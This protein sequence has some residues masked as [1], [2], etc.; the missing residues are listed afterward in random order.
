MQIYQTLQYSDSWREW[1]PSYKALLSNLPAAHI[2][3]GQGGVWLKPGLR[4][5]NSHPIEYGQ[6]EKVQQD[7]ESGEPDREH[8]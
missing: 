6:D 4:H 2:P 7:Y 1:H 3:S 5:S 8:V